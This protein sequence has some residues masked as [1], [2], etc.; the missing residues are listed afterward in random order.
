MFNQKFFL[1]PLQQLNRAAAVLAVIMWPGVVWLWQ[2][3]YPIA[4]MIFWLINIL[5]LW[6]LDN[7]TAFFAATVAS[8][9]AFLVMIKPHVLVKAF[10]F[11]LFF[12]IIAM[13]IWPLTIFSPEKWLA[14][15]CNYTAS[16]ALHRL[17]IW[18]FAVK[19]TIE[20]P[21][22]GWGLNTARIIRGVPR[23]GISKLLWL[24]KWWKPMKSCM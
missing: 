20:K 15:S 17:Y 1:S 11:F 13:P 12:M 4:T 5:I 6:K 2:K 18:Q 8:L 22:T 23:F 19:K 16:S 7:G 3:K 24:P 9:V 10:S 21:V 14:F